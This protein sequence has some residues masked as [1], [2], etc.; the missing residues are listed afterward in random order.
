MPTQETP[1]SLIY[2]VEVVLSLECQISSLRIAIYEGLTDE[3]NAKLRLQELE[4]LD[5]K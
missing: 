1:Y 4:A 3:D 2:G 5:E